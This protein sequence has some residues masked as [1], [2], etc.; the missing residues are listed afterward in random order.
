[1]ATATRWTSTP[2]VIDNNHR[3]LTQF[4]IASDAYESGYGPPG[5]GEPTAWYGDPTAVIVTASESKENIDIAFPG[6]TFMLFLP[7]IVK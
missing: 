7:L 2:Y 6:E 5:E 1:M 3:K 4:L